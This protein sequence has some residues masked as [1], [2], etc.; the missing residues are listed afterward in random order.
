MISNCQFCSL[1]RAQLSWAHL[2][3][4]ELQSRS[5]RRGRG[6]RGLSPG[7]SPLTEPAAAG[8]APETFF[9]NARFREQLLTLGDR[10]DGDAAAF[11]K[12]GIR[13]APGKVPRRVM[14]FY[15][16]GLSWT[17]ATLPRTCSRR[18]TRREHGS[19][20]MPRTHM[21]AH[22]RG[23]QRQPTPGNDH[24]PSPHHH[25]ATHTPKFPPGPEPSSASR[26]RRGE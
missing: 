8:G 1:G 16:R 14:G 5:G 18:Q 23:G 19:C 2:R 17:G 24:R 15:R 6:A 20:L 4:S 25:G 11:Y 12:D 13:L 3:R 22:H 10:L 9:N 21:F 7:L 26:R